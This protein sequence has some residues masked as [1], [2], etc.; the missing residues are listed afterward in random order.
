MN[1]MIYQL[2]DLKDITIYK[3]TV[4][5]YYLLKDSTMQGKVHFGECCPILSVDLFCW[6]V[7]FLVNLVCNKVFLFEVMTT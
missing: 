3:T 7:D 5:H 4:S 2:M 6:I 1:A